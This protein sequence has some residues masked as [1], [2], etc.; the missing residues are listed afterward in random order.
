MAGHFCGYVS[1]P[2]SYKWIAHPPTVNAKLLQHA[3]DGPVPD[4]WLLGTLGLLGHGYW[5]Q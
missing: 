2:Y 1:S 4:A 3:N 5:A